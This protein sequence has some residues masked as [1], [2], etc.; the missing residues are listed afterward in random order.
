MRYTNTQ[1]Y[2]IFKKGRGNRVEYRVS[3]PGL[4]I[5]GD[6][7]LSRRKDHEA[8]T[9][10]R[11]I[12]PN[13]MLISKSACLIDSATTARTKRLLNFASKT[14]TARIFCDRND[15]IDKAKTRAT[16]LKHLGQQISSSHYSI[17][18]KTDARNKWNETTAWCAT[19]NLPQPPNISVA[20]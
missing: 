15:W 20:V 12:T 8:V 16:V 11:R 5:L 14:F 18:N 2:E 17:V 10:A 3:N 7:L 19:N 1:M 6:T 9:I 4:V 13:V